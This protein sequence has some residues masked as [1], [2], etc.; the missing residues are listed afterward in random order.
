MTATAPESTALAAAVEAYSKPDAAEW[1]AFMTEHA[2]DITPMYQRIDVNDG[3]DDGADTRAS[4]RKRKRAAALTDE[5]ASL[6]GLKAS[7][8]PPLIDVL[9]IVQQANLDVL[10][11]GLRGGYSTSRER[12]PLND[13]LLTPRTPQQREDLRQGLQAVV[14]RSIKGGT[15]DLA[16][17][18]CLREYAI[19]VARDNA[20]FGTF[21]HSHVQGWSLFQCAV[22]RAMDAA[23]SKAH[24]LLPAKGDARRAIKSLCKAA[25][26]VLRTMNRYSIRLPN[27]SDIYLGNLYE[28]RCIRMGL[29]G[30]RCARNYLNRA[31]L[32][33]KHSQSA[34]A[35]NDLHSRARPVLLL[36]PPQYH[37]AYVAAADQVMKGLSTHPAV[38]RGTF[39]SVMCYCQ[40]CGQ[41][42]NLA[43]AHYGM[44][45][46]LVDYGSGKRFCASKRHVACGYLP[47]INK[48]LIDRAQHRSYAVVY[49][50]S[51]YVLS[52]CC[53]KLLERPWREI[54]KLYSD[55]N[56]Q[57][58]LVCSACRPQRAPGERTAASSRADD[59]I[60]A[61]S[62]PRIAARI[63]CAHCGAQQT[64]HSVRF[65]A[66][67][68]RLPADNSA[69]ELHFC[70]KHQRAWMRTASTG[71]LKMTVE[72]VLSYINMTS[73]RTTRITPLDASRTLAIR[74]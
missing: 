74:D 69:R 38:N 4:Q 59:E 23:R 60:L 67:R 17:V 3:E 64:S 39:A 54:A 5:T 50:G 70:V 52:S 63:A 58:V 16:L 53:A 21:M 41:V 15:D 55:S 10:H 45:K 43:G 30:N 28:P 11:C 71:E 2:A 66:L 49:G 7:I 61:P 44:N 42:K 33:E 19:H 8:T 57:Q 35:L 9:R 56:P 14:D 51:M 62:P 34:R 72:N 32:Y 40:V 65:H 27:V 29:Y 6:E 26:D 12:A 1:L 68:I 48:Q 37:D 22:L 47:L 73:A 13:A 36:L 20:A 18:Y 25:T 31:E 46:V 24:E